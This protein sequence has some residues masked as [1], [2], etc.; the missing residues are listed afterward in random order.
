M[1]IRIPFLAAL[2]TLGA[3]PALA[4]SCVGEGIGGCHLPTADAIFVGT[5]LSKV[6]ANTP[7]VGDPPAPA[8]AAGGRQTRMVVSSIR[9]ARG[10][11]LTVTFRVSEALRGSL[12][13]EVAVKTT[14]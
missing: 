5:V 9:S 2:L 8:T 4:F 13:G 1:E 6:S 3:H 10:P 11:N 7:P 12:E 14:R